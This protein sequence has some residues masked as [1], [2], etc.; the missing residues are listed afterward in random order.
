MAVD[1]LAFDARYS[2]PGVPSANEV[3]LMWRSTRCGTGPGNPGPR[4]A[5]R[6]TSGRRL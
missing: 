6:R 2:T 4:E 5:D 1:A 3:W